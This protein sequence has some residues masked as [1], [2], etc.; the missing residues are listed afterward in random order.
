ML[1]QMTKEHNW[2]KHDLGTYRIEKKRFGTYTSIR[3]DGTEMVTGMSEEAVK[4]A[5]EEIHMPYYFGEDSSDIHTT[6]YDNP[7]AVDL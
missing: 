7:E 1:S 6:E 3:D 5:T 4:I 2:I